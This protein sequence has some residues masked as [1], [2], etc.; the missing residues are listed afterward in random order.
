MTQ[1]IAISSIKEQKIEARS[2]KA[3]GY[4]RFLKYCLFALCLSAIWQEERLAPPVH[5]GMKLL[6]GKA[7]DYIESNEMLSEAL[8]QAQ[9]SYADLAQ[10]G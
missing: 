5:D 1:Q 3:R 9:K 4:A 8:A 10:G 2:A 7:M 6:A